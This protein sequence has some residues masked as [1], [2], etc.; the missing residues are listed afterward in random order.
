M[1]LRD[2]KIQAR[3]AYLRALT[4]LSRAA[5]V[6]DERA[7]AE[8]MADFRIARRDLESLGYVLGQRDH[9]LPASAPRTVGQRIGKPPVTVAC[10]VCGATWTVSESWADRS[11]YCST[12]CTN[13]AKRTR[14]AVK[15]HNAALRACEG[16]LDPSIVPKTDAP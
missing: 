12:R 8:A 13:R 5:V 15:A 7:Y 1:R 16:Q 4:R 2:L 10:A 9:A 3:D 11:R 14:K 6:E